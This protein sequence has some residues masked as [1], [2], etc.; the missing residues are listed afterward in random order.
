MITYLI[1]CLLG[2]EKSRSDTSSKKQK[3]NDLDNDDD[4][5]SCDYLLI[6]L[7]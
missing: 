3:N 1:L 2:I 7:L 5:D 6:D 4:W